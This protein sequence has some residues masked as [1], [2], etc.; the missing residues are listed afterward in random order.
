MIK[1]LFLALFFICPHLASSQ[2]YEELIEHAITAAQADSLKQAEALYK[3]ALKLSPND[4][5]NVLVYHS[6]GH[7]EELM[8]WQNTSDTKMLE[9]AVYNYSQAI[10]LQ[11][12]SALIRTSRANLFLNLK[13]YDKAILDYTEIIKKDPSDIEALNRRAFAYYEM[14]DYDKARADYEAVLKIN[15]TDYLS[16]LGIVLVLQK[17]NKVSEAVT[18]IGFLIAAYPDRADLYVVRSSLYTDLNKLELALLD[19]NQAVSLEPQNPQNLLHR[20]DLYDKMN[21]HTQARNDRRK[22]QKL[23]IR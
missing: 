7:V 22:A 12:E 13:H 15:P 21:K 18:R 3:M 10:N 2:T 16:A 9:E 4:Y 8:Y 5:R 19:L 23:L 6:L 14:R 20:A 1:N 11:P 17:T